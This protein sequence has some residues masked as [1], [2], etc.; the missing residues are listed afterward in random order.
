MAKA[1]RAPRGTIAVA[2]VGDS[3]T[4]A[5]ISRSGDSI[6]KSAGTSTWMVTDIHEAG[7]GGCTCKRMG[8]WVEQEE[9]IYLRILTSERTRGK[10]RERSFPTH[11]AVMLRFAQSTPLSPN[12]CQL[13]RSFPSHSSDPLNSP[14]PSSAPFAVSDFYRSSVRVEK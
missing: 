4:V 2:A 9:R 8:F 11:L 12:P 13:S 1:V 6:S 3:A 14:L 10:K 5:G 7:F